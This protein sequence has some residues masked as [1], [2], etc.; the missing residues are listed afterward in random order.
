MK[1]LSNA[2]DAV[3]Y[4]HRLL[5]DRRCS[6]CIFQALTEVATLVARSLYAQAGGAADNLSSITA[7]PQIVSV[8]DYYLVVFFF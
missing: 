1:Y 2:S 3:V 6:F 7:D 4:F 8:S 5:T